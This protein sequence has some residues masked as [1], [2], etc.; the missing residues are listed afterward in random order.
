MAS[1]QEGQA[2]AGAG[3]AH[4]SARKQISARSIRPI[5]CVPVESLCPRLQ[6][7]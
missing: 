4:A 6:S 2:N 7:L 5:N 3:Q 1:F